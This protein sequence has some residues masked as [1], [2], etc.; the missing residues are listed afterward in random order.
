VLG[1]RGHQNEDSEKGR[2][3]DRVWETK[4]NQGACISRG[5]NGKAYQGTEKARENE[6]QDLHGKGA[7]DRGQRKRGYVIA[8]AGKAVTESSMGAAGVKYERRGGRSVGARVPKRR[9]EG[10]NERGY[11]AVTKPRRGSRRLGADDEV[12]GSTRML[13]TGPVAE[14]RPCWEGKAGASMID[15]GVW[16]V[17]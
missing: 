8:C 3:L 15:S 1:Q 16:C 11:T 4:H 6:G 12:G 13:W 5:V 9:K 2:K 17:V 7:C 10:H 14:P